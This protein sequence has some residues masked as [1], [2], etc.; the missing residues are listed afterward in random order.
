[1]NRR[2][3]GPVCLILTLILTMALWGGA[4]AADIRFG[5]HV[6]TGDETFIDLGETAVTDFDG[7]AAFL[8]QMP[9][10]RQVN[11]F[12]TRM[13]AER[14]DALAEKFPEIRWGWTMVLRGSDHEH[15]IRTDQTAFSTLHSNK[16]SHHRSED[17]SILKYCWNLFAL[18][19]GHNSVKSLDFL[20]DLP[21]LR[22]LIIACNEVEDIT[23]IAKLKKLEYAELFK[24]N[25]RDMS[26]V[27]GLTNLLDLN[28]CF[29]HIQNLEL[30]KG[31]TWLKRLWMYSARVFNQAYPDAEARG[32]REALPDT[33]VDTKHYSTAGTWRYL[34]S[35][36]TV[37]APHY[38]VITAMF[39]DTS[40]RPKIVYIPFEDSHPFT[41]EELAAIE[42]ARVKYGE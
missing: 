38:A 41:E 17:F 37:K 2:T 8:E 22:V 39:G 33:E 15:L 30:V 40:L 11:M 4:A 18:D 1:M 29:N 12:G 32:Y 31:M 26:P 20:E 23:P 16:T 27:A 35:K 9:K 3:A 6:Y 19:I 25:I 34:D 21:D 13:S 10:V 28:I 42:A 36:N 5:D 7:L 24:N 14:C